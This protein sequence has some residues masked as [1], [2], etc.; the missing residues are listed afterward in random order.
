MYLVDGETTQTKVVVVEQICNF[1]GDG[2]D[3]ES[4]ILVAQIW[5]IFWV[6]ELTSNG[7]KV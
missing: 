5:N 3:F 4:S 2:P 1:V 7:E 6:F